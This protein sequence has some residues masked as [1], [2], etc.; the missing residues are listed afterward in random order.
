[1]SSQN[2][3]PRNTNVLYYENYLLSSPKC[4]TAKYQR[5]SV[6]QCRLI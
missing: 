1:V 2:V 4:R 6:H 5:I 3:A